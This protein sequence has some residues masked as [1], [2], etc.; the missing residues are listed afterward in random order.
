LNALSLV[1]DIKKVITRNEGW[2]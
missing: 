1:N 2:E